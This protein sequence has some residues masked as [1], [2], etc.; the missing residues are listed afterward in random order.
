MN[1]L[2]RLFRNHKVGTKLLV[3]MLFLLIYQNN[4]LDSLM[5]YIVEKKTKQTNKTMFDVIQPNM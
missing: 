5:S 4:A 1:K 3:E 2:T